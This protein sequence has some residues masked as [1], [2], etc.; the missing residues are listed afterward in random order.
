MHILVDVDSCPVKQIIVRLAKPQC[1][2][3]IMLFDTAHEYSDGYSEVI[4]VD[5]QA[6]SVKQKDCIC[7]TTADTN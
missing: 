3:V 5:M 6:D 7:V 2:P 4:I 1:I